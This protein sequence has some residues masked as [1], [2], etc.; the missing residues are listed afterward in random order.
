MK[1][2]KIKKV[3]NINKDLMAERF[4]ITNN[5][6]MKAIALSYDNTENEAPIVIAKGRGSI[7]QKIINSAKEH[8]ISVVQ[9]TKLANSLMPISLGDHIPLE[10]YEAVAHI[11]VYL[12]TIDNKVGD[13]NE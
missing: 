6:L 5:G 4:I 2:E 9:D 1:K 3:D 12:S 8:D 11:F 7:A 13:R 10:I